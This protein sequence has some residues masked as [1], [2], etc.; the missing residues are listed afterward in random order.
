MKNSLNRGIEGRILDEKGNPLEGLVV[1]AEG[2]LSIERAILDNPL[3]K[4]AKKF[5]P[6]SFKNDYELGESKTD[7]KGFYRIKYSPSKYK[8]ILGDKPDIWVVVK[9]SLNSSELKKTDAFK[10]V[11]EAVKKVEDIN[12]PRNWAKGW[13]VT[14]GGSNK[15]RFT[16]DNQVEILIDN[17]TV[18]ESLVQSINKADSYVYLTQFEFNS[19]FQATYTTGEPAE[20]MV[21]VLKRASLRGVDVKIILNENLI[22]PDSYQEIEDIF[23]DSGVEVREFKAHELFMM[24][25]KI[26]VADGKE[27]FVIGS[28]FK[29]EYWDTS[30]HLIKELK[31]EGGPKHDVSVKLEGGSVH[32][33]EEFF[34]QMW[35]YITHEGYEEKGKLNFQPPISQRNSGYN[36]TGKL[37]VQ[38]ARSI[39]PGTF[40]KKGE[41]GIF[42]GYRKAI[43]KA[44]EFIYLENQY[45]T[46]SNVVKALKNALKA[47]RELQIIAV[48]NE[49][50]DIP[51]YKK[52]QEQCLKKLGIESYE[53]ALN[54]PQIGFFTLWS[55]GWENNQ[56]KIQRIYVHTKLAVVDDLW[57]TLGTANLDGSSLTHVN[58]LKGF[59]D[60]KFHRNMEINVLIP[61]LGKNADSEVENI[62]NTLWQEHLGI[63]ISNIQ[64]PPKGW[65][66][67]WQET[68]RQNIKSLNQKK[69]SIKGQI[70]PYSTETSARNQLEDLKIKT[71]EWEVLE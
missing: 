14:L 16:V 19:D 37:P 33:V 49:N 5:S 54:H 40:N 21:D 26:M 53:D 56:F 47:N 52:R 62:R 67:I 65:L 28:P 43:A 70:L 13:Y 61:E 30:Q 36:L 7:K 63:D 25:A 17:Q 41:L 20:Y 12:I 8:N 32:H 69:P 10:A 64:I 35:N 6:I 55:T 50:P 15:S 27:A 42:E 2:A 9:D 46:N 29:Q 4:F 1:I 24:H 59:F 60:R 44:E 18:L 39:T 68:A 3:V 51:T 71:E 23:K 45:F 48:I 22:I 57:A 38:I 66:E 34:T 11:D 58:E 31:R